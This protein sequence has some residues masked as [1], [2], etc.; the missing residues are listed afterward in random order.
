MFAISAAL[1][2]DSICDVRTFMKKNSPSRYP[3]R[4]VLDDMTPNM[5]IA[6]AIIR[7]ASSDGR[8]L[9]TSKRFWKQ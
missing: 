3:V 6:R 7:V 8:S 2:S 4:M 9:A 1:E 5:K